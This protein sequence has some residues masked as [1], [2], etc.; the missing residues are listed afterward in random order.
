[1][2]DIPLLPDSKQ[3]LLISDM[4]GP[5]DILHPSTAPHLKNLQ[6]MKQQHL[7]KGL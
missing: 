1:M 3:H 4:I 6:V 2:W 7:E 5:T